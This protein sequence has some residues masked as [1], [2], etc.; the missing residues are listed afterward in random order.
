MLTSTP[1]QSPVVQRKLATNGLTA[2]QPGYE[3]FDVSEHHFKGD[4][5]QQQY[6]SQDKRIGNGR[7]S[8]RNDI[9]TSRNMT[10]GLRAGLTR[11]SVLA[12]IG[13]LPMGSVISIS[14]MVTDA[15]VYPMGE[16]V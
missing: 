10:H 9:N 11:L 1:A 6:R 16:P 4:R 12:K 2:L 7:Y 3:G 14:S 8:Q 13:L 15:K 5:Y